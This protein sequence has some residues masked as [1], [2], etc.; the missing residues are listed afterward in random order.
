MP[1]DYVAQVDALVAAGRRGDAV[2][3]F[4]TNVGVPAEALPQMQG[5]PMWAAMEDVAHT[6]AY[7]G[8]ILGETQSGKPL[9]PEVVERWS[10]ATMPALVIAGGESEPFFHDAAQALVDVLP[11]GTYRTL[12]GQG[13]GVASEAIAPVLREFFAG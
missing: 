9:R 1:A 12:A 8:I 7:D 3:L 13:H 6:L 11:N 5:T 2:A 10:A 4:M